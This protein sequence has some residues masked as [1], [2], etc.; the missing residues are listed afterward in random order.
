M[1][2]PKT[3]YIS[4]KTHFDNF[5]RAE[6]S[7]RV[8]QFILSLGYSVATTKYSRIWVACLLGATHLLGFLLLPG[9]RVA[10][11]GSVNTNSRGPTEAVQDDTVNF[12]KPCIK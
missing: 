7:D 5:F 4:A 2:A 12:K 1:A 9:C 11:T 10:A 6:A 3:V 8:S